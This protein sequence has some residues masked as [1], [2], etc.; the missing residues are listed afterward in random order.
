MGLSHI[1]H[2]SVNLYIH[3]EKL[4]GSIEAEYNIS[5]W[6]RNSIQDLSYP[7]MKSYFVKNMY[8]GILID[9][10]FVIA[11]LGSKMN[12]GIFIQ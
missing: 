2:G 1:A 10:S 8:I 9:A 3:L 6:P 4:G 5:K 11:K 7:Y 12:C